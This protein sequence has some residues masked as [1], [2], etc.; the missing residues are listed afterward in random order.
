MQ[1]AAYAT[2]TSQ[3]EAYWRTGKVPPRTG[4][5]S[6]GRVPINVYPTKDGY[7]AMN[8]AVEEHWHNLL[9]AMGREDLRDDPRFADNAARVA[10]PRGDRRADRRLD[11]DAAARWRFSRS[12]SSA[13]SRWRRC[14]TST[15]SCT[16]AHMHERGILE[17]IEHDEIGRIVVPNSPLRF[18]GADTVA[19]DAEPQAR[20]AQRRDLWRLARPVGRRNRRTEGRRRHLAFGLAEICSGTGLPRP[21]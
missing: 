21:R 18:H 17:W 19:D 3:L 9:A 2:L 8:L 7:V 11:P 4:N 14:A 10:Q 1:E 20:P 15:R 5:A 12:P 16:T 13:A 6:H